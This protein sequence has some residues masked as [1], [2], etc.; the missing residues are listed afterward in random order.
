MV[1][2]LG[3]VKQV[4]IKKG[5]AI[6]E[7]VPAPMAEAG[8]AL[9]QTAYSCISVGTEMS[10]LRASSAPLWRRALQ[11][12]GNVKK[13][14]RMALDKGLSHTYKTVTGQFM[15]GMPVGYAVC[16]TI[17]ELGSAIS[18]LRVGQLIACAGAQYAHH[19]EY[20]TVPRNLIVPVPERVSPAEASTI[21]LGA[22]ALQGI[23]RAQPTLGETFVVIGMGILGQLTVQMLKANGCRVIGTDV[24][25]AR[26]SLAKSLGL[27]VTVASS[28]SNSVAKIQRL[29]DGHGADG[30]II[31]AASADHEIIAT[32][33][34]MCRRKGRV[35]LV[36]DVGLN[37]NRADFYQKELDFFISTS[38]GPGR[39]DAQ[40][41]EKGLDY[42]IGYVRWTEN[43]NMA[44]YLQLLADGKIKV[45]PLIQATYPIENAPAAYQSLQ[46]PQQKPLM[47]LLSYAAKSA[48]ISRQTLN[49]KARPAKTGQLRIALIGAGGFAKS[50]HLPN[51]QTLA[52]D[53]HIQ[54]IMSRTGHNAEALA[55]NCNAAYATT[56]IDRILADADID[57]VIIVTRH[58][59][60]ADLALAA[61]AAGKH[62]LVEKPLAIRPEALKKIEDFYSDGQTIK[63]ILMTG[64][65]RR[66]SIHAR[67]IRE[68][69][70][71]RTNPLILNY[72]MNA[73][74]IPLDSW[75][76]GEEGGGRNIGEACHIYDL[77]TFLTDSRVQKIEAQAI[78][79]AT[80]YYSPRDNFVVTLTFADG[81]V[82]T[83]TYTALGTGDYPKELLEIY[84]DGRVVLLENYQKLSVFGAKAAGL[85]TKT[86]DKGQLDELRFFANGIRKGEWPIPL[87]QQVQATEIAFAVESQ[88]RR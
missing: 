67:Q 75:V 86:I 54:A 52:K 44:A 3:T 27:D 2:G 5:A 36:G 16:G 9:V 76:H 17:V 13:A 1:K 40:Y 46:Q 73:G 12:P 41:E 49:P 21:T 83:L 35:V 78:R 80:D 43:R 66:F 38:Y 25:S 30:V 62:V 47:V 68:L 58:N 14:L 34:T 19:A 59:H 81:S 7:E 29:T 42:P 72:R 64:F 50:T 70:D 79:P 26:L 10:G 8:L 77:F 15:L 11:Q 84:S 33:F 63:P 53:Y 39:Y 37:L 69:T 82:A 6:V 18:D 85:S 88:L 65:N 22:I 23:R 20:V 31:T 24:D 87:W 74:Y 48:P 71:E 4:F 45:K 51:L 61:L 55:R 60:H 56:E 28:E 57:A 32:A